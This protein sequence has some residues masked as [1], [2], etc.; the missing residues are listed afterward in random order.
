MRGENDGSPGDLQLFN[1]I[2]EVAA[3]LRVE[4]GG[5]LVQED[6]V[7][8]ANE[9]ARHCQPLL[10]ASGK[11]AD[12]GFALLLQLRKGDGL[13]HGKTLVKETAKEAD[14]LFD[15]DFFGELSFLKLNADALTKFAR[16]VAP[17]VT[18]QGDDAVIGRGE[19][20]AYL[21]GGG[22]ACAIG[23]EQAETLSARNLEIE[24]VDRGD[25]CEGF[26]QAGDD[27]CGRS[28]GLFGN[29]HRFTVLQEWT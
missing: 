17:V 7:R 19:S 16:M 23:A 12:A 21:D 25:L 9:S 3:C 29:W 5:G 22:F 24:A 18:E 14:G 13:L 15:R 4:A 11:S 10:L 8:I 27:E 28:R 2:P 26:M 6:Q 20:L 1:K